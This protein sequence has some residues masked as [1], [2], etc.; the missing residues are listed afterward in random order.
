MMAFKERTQHICRRSHLRTKWRSVRSQE[1]YTINVKHL[2]QQS[3]AH[4]FNVEML[5]H[6]K[7]HK[8]VSVLHQQLTYEINDFLQ[9]PKKSAS[10]VNLWQKNSYKVQVK[11]LKYLP[12]QSLACEV[13][14]KQ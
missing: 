12:S 9:E 11:N 3:I 5:K 6:K 8:K 2:L 1:H 14:R 13:Y 4:N 10:A 7:K